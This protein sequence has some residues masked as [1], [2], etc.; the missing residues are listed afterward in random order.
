MKKTKIA[1]F[2]LT[3]YQKRYIEAVRKKKKFKI[4]V[5]KKERKRARLTGLYSPFGAVSE[6]KPHIL[7]FQHPGKGLSLV[8]RL[9]KR[10]HFLPV[11]LSLFAEDQDTIASLKKTG[12]REWQVV[13][14]AMT[15]ESFANKMVDFKKNIS[16]N[17]P[18]K[19][20]ASLKTALFL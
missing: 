6:F 9:K 2:D 20:R 11:V 5:I 1:F 15:E 17:S 8:R 16:T 14:T 12:I 10:D 3:D 13:S 4:L 18:Q 7:V 19:T